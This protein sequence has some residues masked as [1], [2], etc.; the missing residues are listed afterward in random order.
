MSSNEH[1]FK[2]MVQKGQ[3]TTWVIIL[4]LEKSCQNYLG[5]EMFKN[6][7]LHVS[8]ETEQTLLMKSR[9]FQILH[10]LAGKSTNQYSVH[11]HVRELKPILPSQTGVLMKSRDFHT[12]HILVA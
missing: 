10:V 12:L 11:I 7:T 2:F 8:P 5:I 6:M 1:F 9:G 4:L 3:T